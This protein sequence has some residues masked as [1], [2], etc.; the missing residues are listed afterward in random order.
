MVLNSSILTRNKAINGSG[1]ALM[2]L[3]EHSSASIEK[4]AT[5]M[6]NTAG[7]DGGAVSIYSA[8]AFL[9]AQQVLFEDN[10]AGWNG[11]GIHAQVCIFTIFVQCL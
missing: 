8:S 1:G 5:V 9:T 7:K 3:G 10:K 4:F 6:G 2:M 11:G